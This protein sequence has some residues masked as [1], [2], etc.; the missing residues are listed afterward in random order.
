M[1]AQHHVL[2]QSM[3]K[4]HKSAKHTRRSTTIYPTH[5]ITVII[6]SIVSF[7]CGTIVGWNAASSQHYVGS[8]Q[9]CNKICKQMV[10]DLKKSTY[11]SSEISQSTHMDKAKEGMSKRFSSKLSH[12]ATGLVSINRKD[13]F[14][15]FDFGVPM[16][17]GAEHED[18]L[19]LYNEHT[20]M[21]TSRSLS[22][23]AEYNGDIPK[24]TAHEATENCDT[25]NVVFIKNPA[26]RSKVSQCVALVGGQYQGFHVQRWQRLIGEGPK[27]KTDRSAPLRLTSRM[28]NEGGYDGFL[29]PNKSHVKRHETIMETYFNSLAKIRTELDGILKKIAKGNCV[30]VMTVNRGQSDLLVNFVCSARARGFN[31]DNVIVF[32]TDTFSRDLAESLGLSSYYSHE[33]SALCHNASLSH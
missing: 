17:P 22:R 4:D 26:G 27:G 19:L 23:E 12:W 18:I 13:L 9:N 6:C 10:D 25:M 30:V 14:D 24:T 2:N 11:T 1:P 21:P 3:R 29:M 5:V 7:Y 16:N 28:T 31:L 33:V 20:A 15:T 32:P 8:D